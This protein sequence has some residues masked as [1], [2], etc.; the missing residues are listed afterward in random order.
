VKN[1]FKALTDGGD[2]FEELQAGLSPEEYQKFLSL[3]SKGKTGSWY[4]ADKKPDKVP[5]NN[6]VIT[7]APAN[8]RSSPKNIHYLRIW[9][10]NIVK[11]AVPKGMIL[12]VSTGKFK[13]DEAGKVLYIEFYTFTLKH[14][15][16]NYFVAKSQIELVPDAEKKKR[17]KQGKIP[18]QVLE[19]ILGEEDAPEENISSERIVVTN[20]T[21][22]IFNEKFEKTGTAP[23]N[24]I[25][26]YP[27]MILDAGD[28]KYI[29]V[30]TIQG[31]LRWISADM[32]TIRDNP[33]LKT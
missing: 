4:Y 28:R 25:L 8:V 16:Q 3:V 1:N 27:V 17:E 12:G 14:G 21:A 9:D 23:K 20:G 19:G 5:A 26:G 29:K 15:K 11:K 18:L 22:T 13:Y 10:S 30:K 33:E 6:W 7:T 32:A 2:L 31:L 24:V